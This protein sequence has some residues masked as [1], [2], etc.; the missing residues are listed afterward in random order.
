MEYEKGWGEGRV[1]EREKELFRENLIKREE[2]YRKGKRQIKEKKKGIE[3]GKHKQDREREKE[4]R[5]K[6]K[7]GERRRKREGEKPCMYI[8]S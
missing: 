1:G 7:E 3:R 6:K 2:K 4:E 5:E 8:Y